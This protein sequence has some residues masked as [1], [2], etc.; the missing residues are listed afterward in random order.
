[1]STLRILVCGG[2]EFADRRA[3]Y[4]VSLTNSLAGTRERW[5]YDQI[6]SC[7]Q[8][9]ARHPALTDVDRAEFEAFLKVPDAI[10]VGMSD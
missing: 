3:V 6:E 9:A 7:R 1:M 5:S 2:R 10:R 8:F 4:A